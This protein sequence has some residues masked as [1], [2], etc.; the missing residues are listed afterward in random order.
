MYLISNNDFKTTNEDPYYRT[1]FNIASLLFL[2]CYAPRNYQMLL[3][4][5]SKFVAAV[6]W[7]F[8]SYSESIYQ[9]PEIHI[10][11]FDLK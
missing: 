7:Q 1:E 4:I 9:S 10:M 2:K 8:I 11:R 6:Y 5:F 3:L